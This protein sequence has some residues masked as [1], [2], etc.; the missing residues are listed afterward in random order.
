MSALQLHTMN[1]DKSQK[2]NTEQKGKSQEN[3]H[4]DSAYIKF[5]N[6]QKQNKEGAS[7]G[8]ILV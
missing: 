1:L 6:V 3:K 2:H 8:F 5:K 4:Y 7:L